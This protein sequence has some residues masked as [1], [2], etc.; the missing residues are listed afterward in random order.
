MSYTSAFNATGADSA[1]TLLL[2]LLS[3]AS[4]PATGAA[5]ALGG[6]LLGVALWEVPGADRLVAGH[7]RRGVLAFDHDRQRVSAVV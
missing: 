3:T 7:V 5:G 1:R 6:Y 2:R 4:D